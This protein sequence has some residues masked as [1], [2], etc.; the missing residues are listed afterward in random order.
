MN[1]AWKELP[2]A[3][4]GCVWPQKININYVQIKKVKVEEIAQSEPRKC[5]SKSPW[6]NMISD[7]W[8]DY[9]KTVY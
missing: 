7:R 8:W 4:K 9:L 1:K 2:R 6:F 3:Y 5:G